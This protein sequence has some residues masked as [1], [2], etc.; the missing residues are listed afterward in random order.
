MLQLIVVMRAPLSQKPSTNASISWQ[1]SIWLITF[2]Q[3]TV[4][5]QWCVC[6][7]PTNTVSPPPVSDTRPRMEWAD[8]QCWTGSVSCMS[9]SAE[10]TWWLNFAASW[11][12]ERWCTHQRT[13][14][15]LGESRCSVARKRMY[16][17]SLQTSRYV[18]EVDMAVAPGIIKGAERL[19][20]NRG[21]A[22]EI[23]VTYNV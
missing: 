18:A 8:R 7:M 13:T 12:Y 23:T 11:A 14:W 3:G 19:S 21:K 2:V 20:S 17:I 1:Q 9:T 4:L 16:H 10:R 6:N 22:L 5:L 15:S